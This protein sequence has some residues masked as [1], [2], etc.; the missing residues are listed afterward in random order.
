M[1]RGSEGPAAGLQVGFGRRELAALLKLLP[2]LALPA[3]ERLSVSQGNSTRGSA[4]GQLLG[5]PVE[6]SSWVSL[7]VLGHLVQAQRRHSQETPRKFSA[8]EPCPTLK[9]N[10][11]TRKLEPTHAPVSWDGSTR[12]ARLPAV[13]R[14]RGHHGR[15]PGGTSR[16]LELDNQLRAPGSWTIWAG[17]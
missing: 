15:V 7:Q 17:T 16:V 10:L 1:A 13:L 6:P 11:T 4:V 3:S 14:A 2:Y 9:A 8:L 5:Q 12:E